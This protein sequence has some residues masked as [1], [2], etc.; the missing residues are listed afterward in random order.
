MPCSISTVD[1]LIFDVRFRLFTRLLRLRPPPPKKKITP[2]RLFVF[3][4]MLLGLVTRFCSSSF[5]RGLRTR[6]KKL[7]RES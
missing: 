4:S 2:K 6:E 7:R 1:V 3:I 5:V